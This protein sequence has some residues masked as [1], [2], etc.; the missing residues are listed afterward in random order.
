MLEHNHEDILPD[1]IELTGKELNTGMV[2]P[3]DY[4]QHQKHELED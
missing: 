1:K 3:A 4:S 2:M